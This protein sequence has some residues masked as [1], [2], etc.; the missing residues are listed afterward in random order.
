MEIEMEREICNILEVESTELGDGLDVRIKK[1]RD[2]ENYR[3][4]S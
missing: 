1:R 4:L 2:T 3:F